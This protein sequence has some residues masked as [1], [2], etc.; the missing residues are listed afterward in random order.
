MVIGAVDDGAAV[1]AAC[2]E[3]GV[4]EVIEMEGECGRWKPEPGADFAGGKSV[5]AA[6]YENPE[7]VEAGLVGEGGECGDGFLL[8]HILI[9]IEIWKWCQGYE[10]AWD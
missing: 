1:A 4:F 7:D 6:L 2:D 8:F 3:A 5:G 10:G 9:C